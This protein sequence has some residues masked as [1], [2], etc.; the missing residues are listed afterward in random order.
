MVATNKYQVAVRAMREMVCP[1]CFHRPPGSD[2]LGPEVA[3]SCEDRCAVFVNLPKLMSVAK[4]VNTDPPGVCDRIIN[5]LVCQSCKVSPNGGG[6]FCSARAV[7]TCP[8][9]THTTS[10]IRV[11]E[12]IVRPHGMRR[13]G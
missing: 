4:V 11:L 7:C 12:K 2:E 13:V 6:D 10:V 9:A 1:T 5:E 3:R 8:L